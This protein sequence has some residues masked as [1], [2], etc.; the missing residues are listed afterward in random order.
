MYAPGNY[1]LLV[2]FQSETRYQDSVAY[3]DHGTGGTTAAT[4][5]LD[6]KARDVVL[7]LVDVGAVNTDVL[8]TNKVLAVRGVLGDLG[9]DEVPIVV[10]PSGGSEV[11]T[12]TDTLLV[13]LEPV[14]RAIVGLDAS[15]GSLRHV[16]QTGAGVLELGADSQFGADLVTGIDSQDLGLAGRRKGTLVATSIGAI[17]GGTITKIGGG[18]RGELDRV[19]LGRTSGL[20]DILE[21]RL[22]G[23]TDNV[24]VEEVMSRGHL[25]DGSESES[26]ELHSD[27]AVMIVLKKRKER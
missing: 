10:A 18:V 24:G 23:P 4:L 12:V 11:A 7:R 22:S 20:T 16:D 15:S 13:D 3:L 5:N 2:S 26:R 9:S 17:D 6:L 25:G 1:S 27:R 19:V 21:A 14:A 8:E